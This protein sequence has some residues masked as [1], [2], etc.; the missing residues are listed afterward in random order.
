M[1]SSSS[2]LFLY[3]MNTVCAYLVHVAALLICMHT[4]CMYVCIRHSPLCCY[5]DHISPL[6]HIQYSAHLNNYER[7]LQCGVKQQIRYVFICIFNSNML[8]TFSS[9]RKV[10]FIHSTMKFGTK[11]RYLRDT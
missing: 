4:Q 9:S 8:N 10:H 3:V 6:I 11:I 7:T 2:T 1:T 5:P